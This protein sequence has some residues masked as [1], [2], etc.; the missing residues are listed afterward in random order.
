MPSYQDVIRHGKPGRHGPFY[1]TGSAQ[2]DATTLQQL[3]SG[4]VHG[5]PDRGSDTPSV[6]AWVG[7]L[8]EGRAG[9]EFYTDAAPDAGLPPIRSRWSG[10]RPGVRT[11][12][13]TAIIKATITRYRLRS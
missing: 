5:H 3:A 13:N 2:T 9:I 8:P 11:A 7:E 12:G 4:E 6:D 10:N 1:R